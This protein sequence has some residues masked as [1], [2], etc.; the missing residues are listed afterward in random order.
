M[1]SENMT[2]HAEHMA[3]IR[4][5]TLENIRM[6]QR[7]AD[8][9]AF[10][11]SGCSSLTITPRGIKSMTGS[12]VSIQSADKVGRMAIVYSSDGS[13]VTVLPM[14]SGKAKIYTR[15][16]KKRSKGRSNRRSKENLRRQRRG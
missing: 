15:G 11:G 9:E 7:F 2:N 3:Q 10:V 6:H 8:R 14:M 1:N 16:A 4:G 12:G 5:V 13:I